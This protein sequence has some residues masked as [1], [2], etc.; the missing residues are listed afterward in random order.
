[1]IPSALEYTKASSIDE[2]I[3]AVAAGARP[4][5]GGQSLMPMMQIGRA[6]V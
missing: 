2:A 6:H 1:M 4:L 3:A 5:A